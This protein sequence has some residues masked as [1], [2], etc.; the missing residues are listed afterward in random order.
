MACPVP[1]S[2]RDVILSWQPSTSTGVAGYKVHWG[3]ASGAYGSPIT[4]GTVN[5]FTMTH[6][7]PGTYYYAVTAYNLS[8][9]ES[10]DSNE[11]VAKVTNKCDINS[12]G[13]VNALDI[14][15]L[16]NVILGTTKCP[17][18]NC[19]ING[20][21]AINVLDLSLLNKL[22]LSSSTSTCPY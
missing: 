19:D 21:G 6:V 13:A 9:V 5:T 15:V 1:V 7:P 16:T 11:A 17:N 2:A 4:L 3:T 20:D 10:V 12:D 8:G 14:Q 22:I 18:T